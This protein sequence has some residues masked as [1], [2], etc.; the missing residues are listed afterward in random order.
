MKCKNCGHDVRLYHHYGLQQWRHKGTLWGQL[1][2]IVEEGCIC[3]N[4]EPAK[5]KEMKP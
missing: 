3:F 2:C 1:K 4:P 5:E